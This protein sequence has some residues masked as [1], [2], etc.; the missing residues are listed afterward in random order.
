MD[1]S[2]NQTAARRPSPIR[3]TYVI[4]AAFQ[5]KY[6]IL[7]VVGVFIAS[8]V[9]SS[10]LFGILHERARSAVLNQTNPAAVGAWQSGSIVMIAGL[11]FAAVL[12]AGLGVWTMLVTHRIYGP[13]H[14]IE[15]LLGELAKGRFPRRRPLRRKD[16]FK[17]FYDVFWRTVTNL[18]AAKQRQ[19]ESLTE[20]LALARSTG[21]GDQAA[22]ASLAKRLE[23][24]RNECA[25]ALGDATDE[26]PHGGSTPQNANADKQRILAETAV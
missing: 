6:T 7:V 18:K 3:R 26:T 10:V 14:V 21:E 13:I 17:G 11:T 23:T 19:L 25:V 8:S 22:L 5:W 15:Q 4:N 12:G 2:A 9:I 24:L 1:A 16:E 20:A